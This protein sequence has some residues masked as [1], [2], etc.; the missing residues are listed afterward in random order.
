MD[1]KGILHGS[2]LR[3]RVSKVARGNTLRG[4]HYSGGGNKLIQPINMG[5]TLSQ[6]HGIR[7]DTYKVRPTRGDRQPAN[8]EAV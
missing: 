7:L 6:Q 1:L 2:S 4:A 8:G 3:G 5:R